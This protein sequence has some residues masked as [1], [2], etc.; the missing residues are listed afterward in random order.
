MT[1]N[2]VTIGGG[3]GT[4]VVLSALKSFDFNLS[5]IVS[6][7]DDG[8]STGKLRD[9]YGVLPPGDIRRS[10]VALSSASRSL[11]KLFDFR[12]K[13]GDLDGHNLGNLFLTALEK[14]EGTFYQ[15]VDTASEILNVKGRVIPV[16]LNNVRLHAELENGKVISGET[17]IDIPKHNSEL[18][19]IKTF[20]RPEARANPDAL[21][22]IRKADLIVIGPGDLYTSVIP[23]FLVGNIA[24]TVRFSKARK[25]FVCNM[26]TKQGETNNFSVMDFVSVLERHLGKDVL[27][28]V[29]IN[30]K[31]PGGIRL[32]R[33]AEEKAQLVT[34]PKDYKNKLN[35]TEV[36]KAD[37]LTKSGLIRHDPKK[38]ANQILNLL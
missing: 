38:L 22:A 12:F 9:D 30:S 26:M 25:I 21:G 37:L 29:L 17:N 10:L 23:N 32:K 15:A 4:F 31:R 34:L 6:M 5:A 7:C 1:K 14:T 36:L 8:G 19:I 24:K 13:G 33:Y 18:K 11:R 2:I 27:N 16:T 28:Y 3:T 35:K 20:L